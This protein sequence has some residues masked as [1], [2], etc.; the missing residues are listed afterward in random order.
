MMR[1]E[2]IP[3]GAKVAVVVHRSDDERHVGYW[4]WADQLNPTLWADGQTREEFDRSKRAS[5]ITEDRWGFL[6]PEEN[7]LE[8]SEAIRRMRTFEEYYGYILSHRYLVARAKNVVEVLAGRK[9]HTRR[10]RPHRMRL[11]E[12]PYADE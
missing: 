11:R 2:D 10:G 8:Q 9:P 12:V 5:W 1:E 6:F 4:Y 7:H 3:Y